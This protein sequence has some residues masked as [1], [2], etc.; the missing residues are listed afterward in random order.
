MNVDTRLKEMNFGTWEGQ[1]W[2]AIPRQELDGWTDAFETWRCGD[3]ECVQDVMQ[4]VAAVWDE[5]QA[6]TQATGQPTVWVTHAGVIRAATLISQG[7]RR[8]TLASQWPQDAPSFGQ[9]RC[10]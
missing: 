9:W 10:V 7:V 1:R 3:G 4:R 5:A 6:H 2:D 8:V